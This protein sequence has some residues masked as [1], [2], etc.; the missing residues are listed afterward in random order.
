MSI[1]EHIPDISGAALDASTKASVV[2]VLAKVTEPFVVTDLEAFTVADLKLIASL[3]CPDIQLPR[4]KAGIIDKLFDVFV[5]HSSVPKDPAV[6]PRARA[7]RGKVSAAKSAQDAANAALYARLHLLNDKDNED[8][9]PQDDPAAEEAAASE[10]DDEVEANDESAAD[11]EFE[12]FPEESDQ[13]IPDVEVLGHRRGA[14][15][16]PRA[17][18]SPL[19]RPSSAFASAAAAARQVPKNL[20][21]RSTAGAKTRRK[22]DSSQDG[23]VAVVLKALAQLQ[24]AAPASVAVEATLTSKFERLD[25]TR[26][27]RA[28][29]RVNAMLVEV[30]PDSIT[31]DTRRF[32]QIRD[33]ITSLYNMHEG[34]VLHFVEAHA[35]RHSKFKCEALRWADTIKHVLDLVSLD[36]AGSGNFLFV[37]LQ[38][39]MRIHALMQYDETSDESYLNAVT[40]LSGASLSAGLHSEFEALRKL[41][42][43][44]KPAK[45]RSF[46][47]KAVSGDD[48]STPDAV[49]TAK[50]AV[51][52]KPA[53]NGRSGASP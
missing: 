2:A 1:A 29:L 49:S 40:P 31:S 41:V 16:A 51:T 48:D 45:S 14:E 50:A 10:A 21:G 36:V 3:L 15:V 44:R 11:S 27:V 4:L 46:R 38:P 22:A 17:K 13:D 43:A 19:A 28:I 35:W 18:S 37:A 5:E 23:A 53:P 42:E 25:E 33:L 52:A 39:V 34:H 30:L 32:K 6:P 9:G 8:A 20:S 26:M 7:P 12:E 24:A 47:Q